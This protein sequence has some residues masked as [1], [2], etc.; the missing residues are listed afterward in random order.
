MSKLNTL[1]CRVLFGVAFVLAGL[2]VVEKVANFLGYTFTRSYSPGRLL[3]FAGITLLFVMALLLWE[4]RHV[5][6]AK[7][8]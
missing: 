5:A 4:M 7:R 3:E 8:S 1:L 2:A 6:A